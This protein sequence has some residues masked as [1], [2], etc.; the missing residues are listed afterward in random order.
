MFRKQ[1][2]LS[3]G[4][5][6]VLVL[7]NG[8][9][10]DL[11]LSTSYGDF[12]NSEFWPFK[13]PDTYI[14]PEVP[15][16]CDKRSLHQR[17]YEVSK[18]SKWVDLEIVLSKYATLDGKYGTKDS[19]YWERP[20]EA[21]R[22]ERTYKLLCEKLTEYLKDI[23]QQKLNV[24]SNAAKVLRKLISYAYLYG[25]FS[26]NYT[27]LDTILEKLGVHKKVFYRHMHGD[28][29]SG[30]ILGIE[31]QIN[32]CPLYRFLCKEYNMNYRT[33]FLNYALQEAKEVIIFGHSLGPVDYHYFQSL[34][35]NQSKIDL[36]FPDRKIITI[37]THDTNSKMD[38][39]DQLSIMNNKRLDLLFGNN[40]LNIFRTDGSD[41]D[42]IKDF[43]EHF[44]KK[45]I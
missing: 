29:K 14:N 21:E 3:N 40:I 20:F 8:F 26:F 37:F 7:G 25:I 30:I 33:R 11:G 22:D 42:E 23:E 39:C 28:L 38:I 27:N 4:K 5:D 45:Q 16:D 2:I 1:N 34:F 35:S 36:K 15:H 44:D 13:N 6:T 9:D 12:V 43:L 24:E 32:F 10:L 18:D 17:L 19:L 31:N 41:D